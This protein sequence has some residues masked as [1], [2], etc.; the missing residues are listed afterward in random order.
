[1]RVST[2]TSGQ[3]AT[4]LA[5]VLALL[6]VTACGSSSG[7]RGDLGE[8]QQ[9][10]AT[11]DPAAP[12]ATWVGIDATGSSASDAIMSERMAAIETV[13]TRTAVCGGILKVAVF[14]A[15][16]AATSVLFEGSLKQAGATDNARLLRIPEAVANLMDTVRTG[17]G[18]AAAKLSQAASDVIGQLR[19]GGEWAGQLG[20][21]YHLSMVLLTDGFQTTGVNLGARVYSSDELAALAD[22]PAVPT[23]AGASVMVAGLGRVAKEAPPSAMVEGLVTY[24]TRLCERTG[25]ATCQ[26]VTDFAISGQ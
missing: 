18:P 7:H 23:L 11:C 1:M 14:T 15:S 19:L 3:L 13:A 21:P 9:I 26:A 22:K 5:L 8:L 6:F 2:Q 20:E 17:Y 24:Y 12:P 10:L 25:A 4:Y 16:S